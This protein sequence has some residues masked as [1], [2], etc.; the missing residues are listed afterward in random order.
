MVCDVACGKLSPIRVISFRHLLRLRRAAAIGAKDS[1]N[2]T[3][4]NQPNWRCIGLDNLQ[5][6]GPR[7]CVPAPAAANQFRPQMGMGSEAG[8]IEAPSATSRSQDR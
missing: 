2:V 4:R 3:N 5:N 6:L 7:L 1:T 8:S